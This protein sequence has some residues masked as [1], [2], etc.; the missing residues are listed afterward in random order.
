MTRLQPAPSQSCSRKMTE[1]SLAG[2]EN[3]EVIVNMKESSVAESKI[4]VVLN[5]GG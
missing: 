3:R 1:S 5:D 4:S 2:K